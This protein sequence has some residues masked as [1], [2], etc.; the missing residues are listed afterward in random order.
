VTIDGA[1]V[2]T[3]DLSASR[4]QP[5][6][7]VFASGALSGG[8]HIVTVRTRKAGTQLDAILVLE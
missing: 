6:R 3:V 1:R 2:A 4:T 7:I 8:D 5:R